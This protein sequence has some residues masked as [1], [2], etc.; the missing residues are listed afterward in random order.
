MQVKLNHYQYAWYDR[1]ASDT[2][3]PVG[4]L[5]PNAWGLYDV[6]GNVWE[7]VNDWFDETYYQKSPTDDP[8][9][10]EQG[11]YKV[12]RGGSWRNE[13]RLLR[14]SSR[15]TGDPGRC[16]VGVGFRCAR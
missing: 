5:K 6:H 9:G 13:A 2:T 16:S 8:R 15:L 14:V 7:W 12:G 3:H 10:P 1:N 4:Q 11:V